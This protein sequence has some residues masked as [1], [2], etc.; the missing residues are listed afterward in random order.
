VK[1][2]ELGMHGKPG[3]YVCRLDVDLVVEGP[4]SEEEAQRRAAFLEAIA[5]LP[6]GFLTVR[7]VYDMPADPRELVT[8]SG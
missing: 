8:P 7:M 1:A 6:V 5:G 4:H 3:C 2:S